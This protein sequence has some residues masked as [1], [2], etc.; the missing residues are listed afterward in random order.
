MLWNSLVEGIVKK[1]HN[2]MAIQAAEV[3][4]KEAVK[5][6]YMYYD[7]QLEYIEHQL[8]HSFAFPER[9]KPVCLNIIKKIVNNLSMVYLDSPRRTIEG[10]EAEKESFAEIMSSTGLNL[11]MKLSNRYAKLLK[12]VLI[13][14]VWRKGKLD[15]DIL[16][17]DVLDVEF[18]DTPEDLQAVIITHFPESGKTTEI[19]YTRWTPET[20]QTL[21]YR[22]N[23]IA[24][25]DNPYGILPFI[26]VW[27]RMPTSDFWLEGGDDLICLQ[28]TINERLTDLNYV[29]RMQG[30]GQAYVKGIKQQSEFRLGPG[31]VTILPEDGE[32]GFAKTN[33]PITEI[34]ES[35]DF[36]CKQAAITN[37]LSA[38]VMSIE[39]TE[40]SGISKIVGNR[41]L[42]E[43][44]RDDIELFRR[45]ELQLFDL[46]KIIWNT[47]NP[48]RKISDSSSLQIDFYDPKPQVSLKDQ[49]ETWERQLEMGII[50]AVDIVMEK[51]PD[52]KTR[53]DALAYLLRIQEEQRILSERK[54]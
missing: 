8:A 53:E 17:P 10:S 2:D 14:P 33:A 6:L 18:G 12:T 21:D 4:K 27:D 42:E 5:R 40:E 13:R 41:E 26:P 31:S 11:K 35:I 25:E 1:A 23:V 16:T 46:F 39:P 30:F 3:R 34:L 32:M 48:N 15:L 37:G 45:Y 50:S 9:M 43:L 24:S 38:S 51:N 54:L 28:E 44:R 52:L 20:I 47:H 29:I 49:S 19:T 22:G 36:L 7:E